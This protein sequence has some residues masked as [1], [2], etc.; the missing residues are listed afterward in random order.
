MTRSIPHSEQNIPSWQSPKSPHCQD[1][2]PRAKSNDKFYLKQTA[3]LLLLV[4]SC[5]ILY[6]GA[7]RMF[8]AVEENAATASA[9]SLITHRGPWCLQGWLRQWRKRSSLFIGAQ[10]DM[11]HPTL[12]LTKSW[13][14]VKNK[15]AGRAEWKVT[16]LKS[17]YY[18][19]GIQAAPFRLQLQEWN[20]HCWDS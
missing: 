17:F 11:C 14:D 4:D 18:F 3:I 16:H 9:A 2:L 5:H 8:P 1:H 20:L 15:G 7:A 6:R 10:M 12:S 13:R 19:S